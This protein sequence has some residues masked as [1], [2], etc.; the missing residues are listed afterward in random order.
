MSGGVG[1]AWRHVRENCGAGSRGADP[2]GENGIGQWPATGST[3]DA[4]VRKRLYFT[5][6]EQNVL[7]PIGSYRDFRAWSALTVLGSVVEGDGTTGGV[8]NMHARDEVHLGT[9][10]HIQAG[11]EAHLYTDR[12]FLACE[13]VVAGMQ[14]EGQRSRV[15]SP[16][17]NKSATR[18]GIELRFERSVA[19]AYARPNPCTTELCIGY[20]LPNAAYEV[21]DNQGA[22]VLSGAMAGVSAV[23][24]T[25]HLPAGQYTLRVWAGTDSMAIPFTKL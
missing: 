1:V 23:L 14:M 10:S 3:I 12:T 7:V 5:H 11:S 4:L 2:A 25:A 24:S 15:V 6:T 22:A 17:A 16:T 13:E 8:A 9:E 18:T 21:L 20:S 19:T